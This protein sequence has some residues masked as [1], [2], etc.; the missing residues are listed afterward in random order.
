MLFHQRC[1]S[2]YRIGSLENN[3]SGEIN[4]GTIPDFE[5]LVPGRRT[6]HLQAF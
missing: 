5:F 2:S 6:A 3:L 1:E 4:K